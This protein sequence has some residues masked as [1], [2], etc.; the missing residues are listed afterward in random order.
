MAAEIGVRTGP[1]RDDLRRAARRCGDPDPVRR[2]L[3][4]ALAL[5]GGS[6]S[7]A[8][9]IAGVTLQIVR[10][11]VLRFNADGADGLATRKVPGRASILNHEQRARLAEIAETGPIPAAHGVVRWRLADLAQ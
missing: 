8:A 4:I 2:L 10:D 1:T 11:W 5:D 6:R 7:D 9:K 3:V